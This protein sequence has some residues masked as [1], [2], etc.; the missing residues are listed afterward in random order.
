MSIPL[1]TT[2]TMSQTRSVGTGDMSP[3][4]R[5]FAVI[6]NFYFIIGTPC[7]RERLLAFAAALLGDLDCH[8]PG[9]YLCP[10][11]SDGI[12]VPGLSQLT[13]SETTSI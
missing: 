9:W 10:C 6:K 4:Q 11:L 5:P 3:E 12:I 8:V 1:I 13:S 2:G 7:G